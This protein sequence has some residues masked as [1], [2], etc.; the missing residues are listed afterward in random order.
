[1]THKELMEYIKDLKEDATITICKSSSD[2]PV[3]L[4]LHAER[5]LTRDKILIFLRN[6]LGLAVSVWIAGREL[7]PELIPTAPQAVDYSWAAGKDLL[8]KVDFSFPH[9]EGTNKQFF[10][11]DATLPSGQQ[12]ADVKYVVPFSG[13]A[14]SLWPA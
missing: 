1:M 2:I 5:V 13:I 11:F 3:V 10:V 12:M 7:A 9:S 6:T 4:R 14:P 8:K